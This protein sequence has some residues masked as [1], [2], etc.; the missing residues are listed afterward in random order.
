MIELEELAAPWYSHSILPECPNAI[1]PVRFSDGDR[2]PAAEPPQVEDAP[3][4]IEQRTKH[5]WILALPGCGAVGA[6]CMSE[7]PGEGARVGKCQDSVF[8]RIRKTIDLA[9]FSGFCG[10][11]R[12]PVEDTDDA[13]CVQYHDHAG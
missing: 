8:G 1:A 2:F 5:V 6:F 12:E 11:R 10:R 4:S 13:R 9:R 7:R 3:A